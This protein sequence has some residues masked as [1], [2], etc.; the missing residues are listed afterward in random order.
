MFSLMGPATNQITGRAAR[1]V[2]PQARSGHLWLV[3]QT[4]PIRTPLPQVWE[5]YAR[6]GWLIDQPLFLPPNRR[7]GLVE[8]WDSTRK[9][10]FYGRDFFQRQSLLD[11]HKGLLLLLG[12]L[13]WEVEINTDLVGGFNPSEKY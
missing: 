8:N 1:L 12:F 7:C 2:W 11:F 13:I 3:N 4:P 9:S 10:D 5:K 6:E